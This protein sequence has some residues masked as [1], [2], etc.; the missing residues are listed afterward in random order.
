MQV[1][2][3]HIY[4]DD[5]TSLHPQLW[6]PEQVRFHTAPWKLTTLPFSGH[7]QAIS[8]M[9]HPVRLH[10]HRKIW[11][12]CCLKEDHIC[13]A[14]LNRPFLLQHHSSVKN[15]HSGL[16]LPALEKGL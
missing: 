7:C 10:R 13:T 3:P 11:L 14:F 12:C 1:P 5:R 6:I 8:R 15:L 16:Y 2:C 4:G 9:Q